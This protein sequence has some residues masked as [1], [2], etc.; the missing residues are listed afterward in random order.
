MT[1]IGD[2]Y[3]SDDDDD[4]TTTPANFGEVHELLKKLKEK[5][6]G[7]KSDR[8]KTHGFAEAKRLQQKQNDS[9]EKRPK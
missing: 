9:T 7:Q 5:T 4:V 1:D 2:E 8:F 3:F 6:D